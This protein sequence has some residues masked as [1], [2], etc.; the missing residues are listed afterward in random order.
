MTKSRLRAKRL[1]STFD[2]I[3]FLLTFVFLVGIRSVS[4]LMENMVF[5]SAYFILLLA[6]IVMNSTKRILG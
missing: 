3:I 4:A 1:L 5:V 6:Y 2:I